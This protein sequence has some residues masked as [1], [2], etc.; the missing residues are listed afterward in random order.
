MIYLHQLLSKDPS[1]MSIYSLINSSWFFGVIC[2][3]LS[4]IVTIMLSRAILLPK[5]DREYSKRVT[6]ANN[7][8]V[9]HLRQG[10]SESINPNIKIIEIMISATARKY[11]LN[12][13]DLYGVKKITEDLIKEVMGCP[14]VS[15]SNKR[16]YCDSL[17]NIINRDIERNAYRKEL[18]SGAYEYE[19]ALIKMMRKQVLTH[20]C[21][22]L[23]GIV[24]TATLILMY[25]K[26]S[27]PMTVIAN[28]LVDDSL[29]FFIPLVAALMVLVVSFLCQSLSRKKPLLPASAPEKKAVEQTAEKT[30]QSMLF[31]I[32]DRHKSDEVRQDK[33]I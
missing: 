7:E 18:S 21:F 25:V 19:A 27:R 32:K 33:V 2:S 28:N 4:G 30:E 3:V 13:K 16:N 10:V 23:G 6:C 8:I 1:N 17:L 24:S 14:F 12:E 11:G 26:E 9:H 5:D 29:I 15:A 31:D 22:L 20:S